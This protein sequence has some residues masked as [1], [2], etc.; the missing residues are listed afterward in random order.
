MLKMTANTK[1]T[2]LSLY[3][4]TSCTTLVQGWLSYF[5]V[6]GAG[7]HLRLYRIVAAESSLGVA[8]DGLALGFFTE[9]I[10]D[11]R[12]L[13]LARDVLDVVLAT[14]AFD[15]DFAE[16]GVEGTNSLTVV[17]TELPLRRLYRD[18]AGDLT[19]VSSGPVSIGSTTDAVA[20]LQSK[21]VLIVA[22]CKE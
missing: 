22:D 21:G 9:V 16:D 18:E 17:A 5:R 19:S 14:L 15:E 13:G 20:L 12:L 6:A 3:V 11:C 4:S 1:P 2:P 7:R 10:V 8:R